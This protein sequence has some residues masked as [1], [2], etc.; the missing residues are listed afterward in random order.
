MEFLDQQRRRL[1]QEIFL[2][3]GEFNLIQPYKSNSDKNSEFNICKYLQ[4]CLEQ[5][6]ANLNTIKT[7]LI[8]QYP[9]DDTR[10]DQQVKIAE[11][12]IQYLE[13]L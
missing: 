1:G 10:Y 5:K 3:V 4:D 12:A 8:T 9:L 7:R 13:E 6:Q 2:Q 11:E